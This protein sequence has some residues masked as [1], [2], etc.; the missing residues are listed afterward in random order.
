MNVNELADKLD[1]LEIVYRLP[2]QLIGNET[3]EQAALRCNPNLT[4]KKE[5]ATMLRQQQAEIEELKAKMSLNSYDDVKNVANQLL[6]AEIAKLKKQLALWRLSK[7]SK[8]IEQVPTNPTLMGGLAEPVAW[9]DKNTGKPRME[10]FIKT[11]Y[12]IPLYTH[13]SKDLTDEE[14]E[15]FAYAFELWQM[16]NPDKVLEGIIDFAKAILKKAQ[17]K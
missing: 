1:K 10:G 5:A 11:D 17:E 8:K 6:Q 16:N 2:N 12:D 14:I 7:S 3:H 9:I 4:I 13:P 15:A